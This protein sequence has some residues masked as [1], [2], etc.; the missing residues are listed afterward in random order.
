M[1]TFTNLPDLLV[2]GPCT[3]ARKSLIGLKA[4][5]PQLATAPSNGP[6]YCI[7]SLGVRS[8][9][10]VQYGLTV[11]LLKLHLLFDPVPAT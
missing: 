7:P 2:P 11:K 3:V 6:P 5:L 10:W 8:S 1:T 4:T 9:T